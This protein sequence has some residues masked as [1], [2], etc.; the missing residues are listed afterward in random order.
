MQ[1]GVAAK[2]VTARRNLLPDFKRE[3]LERA[4]GGMRVLGGVLALLLGKFFISV[5]YEPVFVFG[6][7][8][9]T[10]GLVTLRQDPAAGSETVKRARS[11]AITAGDVLFALVSL[12][13][14]SADP[15][16]S[17][18]PLIAP[19][20]LVAAFRLGPRG[21]FGAAV[22]N[23]FGYL[24]VALF[25]FQHFGYPVEPIQLALLATLSF[26]LAIVVT[27][28]LIDAEAL[29]AV[30]R[31]L[32]EPLLEAQSR[33]GE[34]VVVS[35][36]GYAVYLSDAVPEFTGLTFEQ[37]TNTPLRELFPQL[38]AQ[39]GSRDDRAD[40]GVRYFESTLEQADGKLAHVELNVTDLAPVGDLLRSL[41]VARDITERIKANAELERLAIHDPLTGLPNKTLLGDRLSRL[42][43]R[44]SENER[45]V[46][47]YFDLDRLKHVNDAFGHK[48]GDAVLVEVA[49]RLQAV[50]TP[51]D[52]VA[53]YD[54]D[55]F[56]VVLFNEGDRA[57]ERAVELTELVAAP[58]VVEGHVVHPTVT[59]GVAIA[60]DHGND[61]ATLIRAAEAAM[62]KAKT[63][64]NVF[65]IYAKEDDRHGAQ[66]IELIHDLRE[67][68]DRN[69][70]WLTYQ[71]IVSMVTAAPV[72][73]E[74]LLRWNHPTHGAI[75][76][77]DFIPIAEKSGS[78][79]RIGLWVLD[80]AVRSCASWPK[81]GPGINVNMSLRNLRMPELK[82]A[83]SAALEKWMLPQGALTVE[84]TESIV[85]EDPEAMI[86]LLQELSEMGIRGSVDDYGTGYSSLAYLLRLPVREM[87][88]DRA[89]VK[90]MVTNPKSETIVHSTIDLAH[91]LGLLVVAEGVEDQATWD[92]LA[93]RGCDLA[94]GYFI[95]R[96]MSADDLQIWL[97]ERSSSLELPTFN[98]T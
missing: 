11:M 34:L 37:L 13:L 63:E 51:R 64:G 49:A 97:R 72:S 74:A 68:I 88:I 19:L 59:A 57:M 28:I 25:R 9:I 96:P 70:M 79:K 22:A 29:R 71:P 81:G 33:L 18:A 94:Q 5:G 40:G 66:Q 44:V 98:V 90:D 86:K 65:A 17:V 58:I 78:I 53:R 75:S 60:P 16:W 76:P 15:A 82:A 3:Q 7:L 10:F 20:V 30:R 2:G 56:A 67:A 55:E 41:I 61:A 31:E 46:V 62:Y 6:A 48:G 47:L 91:D 50:M 27:A 84:I 52:S 8:L 35:E 24:I 39:V 1:K 54:A 95:A 21:A 85:M 45:T 80:Q 69:E 77:L 87:K 32:Y 42:L 14:Y 89:F 92:A 12:L 23:T 38:A 4:V 73:V 93:A 83:I 43:G 26:F 36:G